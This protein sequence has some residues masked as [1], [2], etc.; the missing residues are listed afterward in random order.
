M[1]NIWIWVVIVAV[2][3]A[4]GAFFF[5]KGGIG[6]FTAMGNT[7]L[8]SLL[9]A[10]SSQKCSFSNAQSSGTIYVGDGRMRGDFTSKAGD[11]TA[12]SHM[13]IANNIAYVWI[14]GT[15]QGYRMAFE[16]L[17]AGG[18]NTS[19]GIDAD[20]KVATDC[21]SWQANE[22]SFELPASVSFNA[23]GTTPAQQTSTT[24]SQGSNTSG[25]SAKASAGTEGTLS[26]HEQQC[27]GCSQIADATGKAQ[28]KASFDCE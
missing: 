23:L 25:T 27:A 15:N 19:G 10:N 7:S 16:D 4:A 14:D 11:A 2:V 1:K 5:M 13:I 8:R 20:A 12:Q 3:V 18:S 22:A 9:S 28:C 21:T 26:Y 17:K 24:T 6:N